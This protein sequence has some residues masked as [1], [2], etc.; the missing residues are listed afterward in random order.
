REAL[1]A[2]VAGRPGVDSRVVDLMVRQ[3]DPDHHPGEGNDA[4]GG[5]Q[6]G[7][8]HVCLA[9]PAALAG[10]AP[11]SGTAGPPVP[12]PNPGG[13]RS[14][15]T[16]TSGR[17]EGLAELARDLAQIRVLDP[18]CGSGAFLLGALSQLARLREALGAVP[19]GGRA[20]LRREI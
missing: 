10:A 17:A 9:R 3:R 1:A 16:A 15:L 5:H 7:S 13:S 14:A 6:P 4:S 12:G 19:P 8:A 2:Y 18:A 11:G 20:A